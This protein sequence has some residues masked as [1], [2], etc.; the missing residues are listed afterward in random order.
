MAL[1]TNNAMNRKIIKLE[2][3]CKRVQKENK[4]RKKTVLVRKIDALMSDL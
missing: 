4:M 3:R 1:V 2:G